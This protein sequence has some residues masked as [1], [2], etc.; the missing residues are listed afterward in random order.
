[1]ETWLETVKAKGE[2]P[3]PPN[4]AV[5][6]YATEVGI[7]NEFLRLAWV[8]FRHRYTQPEAKRYRDWRA[9]FRKAVRGNWLKLWW[10]DPASGQYALTTVGLQAQRSHDQ[11]QGG[12]A[13]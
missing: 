1:M 7:P 9:V 3:V 12:R 8:E 6:A 4:D 2:K 10:L 13:A 11:Q 5:F